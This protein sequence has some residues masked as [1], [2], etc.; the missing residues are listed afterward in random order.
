MAGLNLHHQCH[1]AIG[2][3]YPHS[4]RQDFQMKGRI[5]RM[6]Q[7]VPPTWYTLVTEGS[8]SLVIEDRVCRKIIPEIVFAARIPKF[9]TGPKLRH[10]VAYEILRFR[11]G[12][13][14]NRFVW[15]IN[16]PV[17]PLDYTDHKM[18]RRAWAG[19]QRDRTCRYQ[20]PSTRGVYWVHARFA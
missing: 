5:S 2:M 6:G 19:W 8:Y 4:Y 11:G 20:V 15:A 16:P 18:A 10:P 1:I 3:M 9:I 17:T 7:R 13:P 14:F 12:H